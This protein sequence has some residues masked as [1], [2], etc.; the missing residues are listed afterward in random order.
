MFQKISFSWERFPALF[1]AASLISGGMLSLGLVFPLLFALTHKKRS[2]KIGYLA[3]SIFT[4][5]LFLLFKPVKPSETKSLIKGYLKPIKIKQI[6]GRLYLLA[7]LPYLLNDK[8]EEFSNITCFLSLSKYK[9]PKLHHHFIVSG[10][11]KKS[12]MGYFLAAKSWKAVP[13]SFSLTE[14]RFALQEKA[15][16]LIK[17][18]TRSKDSENY[19][20]SLVTGNI[21]DKFLKERFL[22]AGILHC[23]AISG[24]HFSWII[25]LLSIPLNLLL[26]KKHSIITL[27]CLALCYFL[28]IGSSLSVSR[29]YIAITIYLLTLLF[30]HVSLPLNALGVA[31]IASIV[32]DPYSIFELSFSLSFLATFTILTLFPLAERLTCK[33]S[34][35]RIKETLLLMPLSHKVPY[36]LLRFSLLSFFVSLLINLALLPLFISNFPF[37]SL[38][39]LF[40]NIFFPVSMIPTLLLLLA[41]FIL[42]PL[43]GSSLIWRLNEILTLPFLEMI[44]Y[45]KGSSYLLVK[46]T[47][48]NNHLLCLLGFGFIFFALQREHSHFEELLVDEMVLT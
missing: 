28:F 11:L 45:G 17:Q 47:P 19:F 35:K 44:L 33:V 23:L 39:G 31:A 12:S 8:G 43:F 29:S 37:F 9:R 20:T 25:F 10:V 3:L 13:Y 24:F 1:I 36:Y 4:A 21:S 5:A 32:L 42:H 38:W 40:F 48:I 27:L 30:S 18:N 2:F 41:A 46:L 15:T 16:S 14:K 26:P 6:E 7:H 22:S 34:P